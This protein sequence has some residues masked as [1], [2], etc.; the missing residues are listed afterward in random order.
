MQGEAEVQLPCPVEESKTDVV[1]HGKHRDEDFNGGR[2]VDVGIVDAMVKLTDVVDVMGIAV[3]VAVDVA[4]D[5]HCG[6]PIMD[7]SGGALDDADAD[8]SADASGGPD[9]SADAGSNACVDADVMFDKGV[10]ASHTLRR[11]CS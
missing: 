11:L 4:K 9:A 5:Q 6:R 1:V 2:V 8:A 7:D 3:D 10:T